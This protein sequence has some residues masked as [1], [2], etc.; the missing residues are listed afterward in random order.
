[1]AMLNN[2][3]VAQ[4]NYWLLLLARPKNMYQNR[5]AIDHAISEMEQTHKLIKLCAPE[6]DMGQ[7]TGC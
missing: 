5:L 7:I 6:V 1:M 2:Q 3:R 4:L